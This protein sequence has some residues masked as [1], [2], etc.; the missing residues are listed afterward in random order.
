MSDDDD[1]EDDDVMDE[2][3]EKALKG[4]IAEP[5]DEVM[6]KISS[7]HDFLMNRRRKTKMSTN[8]PLRVN[9]K[10]MKKSMMTI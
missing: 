7:M 8:N 3:T 1:D 6:T 9:L 4:F 2:E 5:G 10:L